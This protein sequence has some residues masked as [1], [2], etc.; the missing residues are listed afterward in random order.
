M[1]N[2]GTAAQERPN[3]L[4]GLLSI[5]S[6]KIIN[7]DLWVSLTMNRMKIPPKLLRVLKEPEWHSFSTYPRTQAGSLS[8]TDAAVSQ[9]STSTSTYHVGIS[10]ILCLINYRFGISM[11]WLSLHWLF[12][13]AKPKNVEICVKCMRQITA[14]SGLRGTQRSCLLMR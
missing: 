8:S 7:N 3:F 14:Q 9:T 2:S 12:L 11:Q 6:Q 1:P 10:T 13:V 4:S 5:S